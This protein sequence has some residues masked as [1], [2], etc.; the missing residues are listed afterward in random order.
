M[1]S[2]ARLDLPEPESP[3]TTISESRGSSIDTFFKLCTRAPCTPM[4]VRGAGLAAGFGLEL[5][6][7]LGAFVRVEERQLFHI[8]VALLGQP[9]RQRRFH[10]N[11]TSMWKS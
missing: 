7:N 9:H 10:K 4:V 3:V 6:G 5:I 8:D 2:N 1:V 11:A